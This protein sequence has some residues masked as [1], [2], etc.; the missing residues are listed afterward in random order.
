MLRR[1]R[2]ASVVVVLGLAVVA[3]CGD[4]GGGSP[5]STDGVTSSTGPS[6]V[7][8]DEPTVCATTA[9]DPSST[10]TIR[11]ADDSDG[12]GS[13]GTR[14]PSNLSA[15]TVRVVVEAAEDNPDPVDVELVQGSSIVFGFVAVDPGVECGADVE[16]A[17]G[18][19]TVRHED[20]EKSFTV[21]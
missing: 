11:V 5:S 17:A 15:G 18:T 12:F 20:D 10:V 4:D 1:A 9:A 16:L 14:V 3:G 7:D 6:D 21:G 19:Y 13:F 2:T 8:D